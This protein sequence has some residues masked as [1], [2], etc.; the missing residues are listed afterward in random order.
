MSPQDEQQVIALYSSILDAWNRRSAQ[1]FATGFSEQGSIVG[2]DGS[3]VDGRGEIVSHLGPIFAGH[4]TP[5]YVSKVRE[6]RALSAESAMLRAVAGMVP[7]GHTDI[8][9]ALNSIQT[10]V[11]TKQAGAWRAE[12]LQ[13]TP[14]A[15]H[16]RPEFV[17]QLT[18]E[19][20][21]ELGR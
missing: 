3:Q 15:F 7:A 21:A 11:A 13:T 17:E 9:A 5:T 20:R 10:L 18:A 4:P 19:L 1:N 2:F 6:V 16:G 12:M 14:A 8:N